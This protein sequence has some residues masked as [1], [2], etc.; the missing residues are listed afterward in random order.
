MTD[1]QPFPFTPVPSAST[2]HDGWTPARQG[3]FLEQLCRIGMVSAAAQAVGMSAKSA[4]ALRKRAGAE[5]FSAAWDK[6]VKEGRF[7]SLSTAIDRC[8]NGVATPVFYRGRKVG[9]RLRYDTSLLIAT[10][11]ATA[12]STKSNVST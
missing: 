5:N 10:I 3:A 1:S 6:A 9:E 2:R 4:Y 11:R 12:S 8:L 7:R